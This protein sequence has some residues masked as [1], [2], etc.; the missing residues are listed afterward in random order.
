MRRKAMDR[1]SEIIK[2]HLE[3]NHPQEYRQMQKAG[4]LQEYLKLNSEA[5]Y[6]QKQRLVESGM[7]DDMAEEMVI[8]SLFN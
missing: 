4:E 8:A 3:E 1:Y 7:P 6:Q 2:I 5:A